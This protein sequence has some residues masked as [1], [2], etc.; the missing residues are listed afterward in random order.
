MLFF[1]Q[2]DTRWDGIVDNIGTSKLF[3]LNI[4]AMWLRC[5]LI[6]SRVAASVSLLASTSMMPPSDNSSK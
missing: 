4:V 3:E 1:H 2:W 5:S 6:W